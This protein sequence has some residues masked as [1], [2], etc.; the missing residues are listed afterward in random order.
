MRSNGELVDHLVER[1]V[2]RTPRIIRAFRDVDRRD[3]VVPETERHTYSDTSLKHLA[4]QTIPQP[5][6]VAIMLEML[7]PGGRC[8]DVGTGSGYT[9]ALLAHLCKEVHTIERIPKLHEFARRT[10]A[11]YENVELHLGDG[12]EGVPGREF[13]RILVTAGG[14]S[15]PDALKGQLKEGGVLVMPVEGSLVKGT[16]DNGDFSIVKKRWG[17]AFV[18]LRSGVG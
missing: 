10:L 2:L 7:Q 11:D 4:G 14:E 16:R 1:G 12:R 3:F 15:V 8:L 18:P 6:T 13:D 9:A 5:S 17:F